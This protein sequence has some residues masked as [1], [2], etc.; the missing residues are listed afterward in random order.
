MRSC[1][2]CVRRRHQKTALSARPGAATVMGMKSRVIQ[3]DPPVRAAATGPI[4][5]IRA[6]PIVTFFVLAY[7]LSWGGLP[8]DSFFAPGVLVAALIVAYI[9]DG[10]AGLR[11]IGARLIRWRVGWV[12]YALAIA[13]P[14]AIHVVT[15][16]VNLALGAP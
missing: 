12:W 5:W 16:S 15:V 7:A 9:R 14:L 10:W 3:D 11:E 4:A 2:T 1:C 13:V 8:W 6:H